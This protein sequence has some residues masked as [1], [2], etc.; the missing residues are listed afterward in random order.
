L[1]NVFDV[2]LEPGLSDVLER[3][4][5]LDDAIVT[6]WSNRMHVLPAGKLRV[7][8]HKLL[9]NGVL[10]NLLAELKLRYRYIIIDTPPVLAAAES[11]VLARAADATLLCAKRDFS[12][13]EQVKA[14]CQRLIASGARPVG[15]VLNGVPPRAYAYHYGSY[16]YSRD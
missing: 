14:A 7:S 10:E 5:P 11:L 1:H 16:E 3:K 12:R 4:S 15:T 6:S 9:G 8:P 2:P 13:V